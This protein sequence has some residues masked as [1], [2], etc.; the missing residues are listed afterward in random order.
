MDKCTSALRTLQW[1]TRA[2]LGYRCFGV[3]LHAEGRASCRVWRRHTEELEKNENAR[4]NTTA[5]AIACIRKHREEVSRQW[6][7]PRR[8]NHREEKLREEENKRAMPE[9]EE[10][11]RKNNAFVEA[12][13]HF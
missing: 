10:E 8:K 3:R 9:D 6:S 13:K 4:D 7:M 5:K 11:K 1:L 12:S 2:V